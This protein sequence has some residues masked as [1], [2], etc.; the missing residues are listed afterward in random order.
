MDGGGLQND[1]LQE[2]LW[3]DLRGNKKSACTSLKTGE[4]LA[5]TLSVDTG[6]EAALRYM[7]SQILHAGGQSVPPADRGSCI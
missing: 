3:V 7:L 5:G 1:A 2:A 4:H 6:Q